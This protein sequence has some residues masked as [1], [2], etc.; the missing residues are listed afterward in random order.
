VQ[1]HSRDLRPRKTLSWSSLPL[2]SRTASRLP[3][4]R[5]HRDHLRGRG[6]L[7]SPGIA[8]PEVLA[9][10][11]H[12]YAGCPVR[13]RTGRVAPTSGAEGEG[14][15]AFT[16]A[17]LRV[18][19]PLDGS[20]CVRGPCELLPE[21]TDC[22]DA[23]TLRGP[24]SCRSRPWSRSTELSLP[25]EPYPLS[26]ASCFPVGSRSTAQR[27]DRGER[28]AARFPGASISCRGSPACLHAPCGTC[29]FC[30]W[31]DCKTVTTVPSSR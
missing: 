21:P 24:V 30:G 8:S 20:G 5:D 28:F 31:P 4:L 15:Q 3:A 13:R 2:Q 29:W 26:Q 18:L 17:V 9:P 27:R 1:P 7:S 23:P 25:E 14:R 6:V 19:A 16:G 12:M 22:R 10:V 11:E